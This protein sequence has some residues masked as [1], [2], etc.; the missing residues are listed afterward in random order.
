MAADNLLQE[1]PPVSTQSWEDSIAKDLKGADYTRKLIWQTEE[2]LAV[3]PYYR[4]EDIIG[5]EFLDAAPG[6]FPYVRSSRLTG[7][8]RIREEI[9]AANPEQA[10]HAAQS[11]VAAGA[12]EIAFCNVAAPNASDLGMLLVNLQTISAHFQNAGEPLLR[13]LIERLK[14]RQ[15]SAPISTGWNP[16]TN[17][18]FAAEVIRTA[19]PTLVPF[20]IDGSAFEESGATAVEEVGFTLAAAVDFLAEMQSRNVGFVRAV[21]SIGFSFAIGANY[22]FQIAKLRAFR[23]LWARAIES[24]GGAVEGARTRIHARTSRWNKTIYDPH[25]NVLRATT[26]AMS[27]VL[28]GADSISSAA[29]DECYKAPDEASRR[30][31][32]NTQIILKREALLS[33]VADPGAGSYYLEVITDFIACEGWKSMQK[34]EAVG[35][36]RKSDADGLLSKALKRS[37]A[38]RERAVLLRRRI[39]TGTN[40]Y[41]D[42]SEKALDRIDRSHLSGNQRGAHSYEQLRL[43]T[44][45]HA[46]ETGWLPRVLLAEIGDV[47]LRAAHSRFAANFFACA[48]F[49]IVT[50]R[51]QSSGEIAASDADLIVLCSSDPEYLEL[52][53]E[54]ALRLKELRRKTPVIVAGNPEFTE[55]LRAAG[56]ADFIH[57]RSNP[58]EVLTAWQQQLGIK[59]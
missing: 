1:F 7:D 23:M 59:A 34:I 54:L 6:H 52:V 41:A 49:D 21:T 11:A 19:P 46:A 44:E 50:Q 29:F 16:L 45:R 31:A 55:H 12:E 56:V 48:G 5:L 8:W 13:L 35:G 33:H 14:E 2:G 10:N 27:A 57:A 4:A 18:D 51:F 40:Q 28:G 25:V 15:D 36:Y 58:I 24:F 43:R 53:T 22:F 38:A 17:L 20:T 30:L 32:R 39:F 47:K 37:L 26:E 3:K 9:D 42:P